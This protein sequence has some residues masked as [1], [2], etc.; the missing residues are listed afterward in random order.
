M[1]QQDK[2]D[3][4]VTINNG[5]ALRSIQQLEGASRRLRRE[6]RKATTEA[7]RKKLASDLKRVNTELRTLRAETRP[8]TNGLGKLTSSFN[9][10]AGVAAG[11]V[12]FQ[13]ITETFNNLIQRGAKL[14]DALS[15][16]QK[17]TGLT[18]QEVR[19]LDKDLRGIDTRS[20]R[21]ELLALAKEGGRLGITGVA[22]LRRFVEEADKINVALGEDLGDDAVLQIGKIADAFDTSMT[23]IAS[24][25]NT[26]GQNTKAQE[27]YLVDFVARMQGT[28]R[29]ANLSA[30]EIIGFGAT[31]DSLG[32]KVEMSGT[33]LN[34]FF[35]DF[36]KNTQDYAEAAGFAD[37]ELQKIIGEEGTNAGFLA[38]I[39]RLR[40]AN[41]ESDKFLQKLEDLGINGARGAQVFLA[42]SENLK[43]VHDNQ[44]MANDA[45]NEGTSI[46]E[47]F[48]TRNNNFAA[49]VNRV[50]K[51]L[52]SAFMNSA[53]ME[54]VQGI[55][56][57]LSDYLRVPLSEKLEK[58][59][60]QLN[61]L[62]GRITEL[63]TDN[64]T[65]RDLLQQLNAEYPDFLKNIDTETASND[66]LL[67]RLKQ[68]NEQMVNRLIIQRKQEEV[69]DQ[70]EKIASAKI[71]QMETEA[72]IRTRLQEIANEYN[73]ELDQ[74]A[75]LTEKYN[76]V[77]KHLSDGFNSYGMLVDK[78]K[79]RNH[80][81]YELQIELRG[82]TSAYNRAV[83]EGNDLIS[84]REML[85]KQLGLQLEKSID[86]E[87]DDG[88]DDDD[89]DVTGVSK[90]ELERKKQLYQQWLKELQTLQLQSI[91]DVE[92]QKIAKSKA[93]YDEERARIEQEV[94]DEDLKHELLAQLYR[95]F[96]SEKDEIHAIATEERLKAEAKKV[97]DANSSE[98]FTLQ[99]KYD[100]A[101]DGS[102]EQLQAL[103]NLLYKQM[104]LELES[105]ELTKEQK[106]L[107]QQDYSNRMDAIWDDYR[108]RQKEKDLEQLEWSEMTFGQRMEMINSYISTYG[109]MMLDMMNMVFD[110]ANQNLEAEHENFIATQEAEKE[111]LDQQLQDKVINKATYDQ[112]MLKMEEERERKERALK[113][114][115]FA[116]DKAARATQAI[117]NVA[118]GVTSAL[119]VPPPA[120]YIL[121]ALTAAMGAA[122]VAVITSQPNP[123]Y[124]GGYTDITDTEGNRHHA[125]NIGSFAD[126]GYYSTASYGVVGE[127]GTE[128]VVPNHVLNN[129][130]Y[131]DS[132]AHI[133]RAIYR[134]DLTTP[135]ADGG[136][137]KTKVTS[138]GK[139]SDSVMQPPNK[140]GKEVS[141]Q[142]LTM[143]LAAL[144]G[145][146]TKLNNAL[147]ANG[148]FFKGIWEWDAF[149]EGVYQ[150]EE[151]EGRHYFD[152]DTRG[153]VFNARDP[154]EKV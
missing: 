149:T 150:Q 137:T 9:K 56:G 110:F 93:A 41:P 101:E 86:G 5:E 147:D 49:D 60:V 109:N 138:T 53:I 87:G 122:E 30:S 64:E 26:L 13:V 20:S 125:M 36:V 70:N 144:T 153:L 71:K 90:E 73:I 117:I 24:S 83:E 123:Y 58:E 35:I 92:Q 46:L 112:K 141:N 32:L 44:R 65:R 146:M 145:Q 102:M 8:A 16:V 1:S 59:N 115:Q 104:T 34:N 103:E 47:E 31:L 88:S 27:G 154:G 114:K 128:L 139:D 148:G 54:G 134:K 77:Q 85:M 81:L 51:A 95:N 130:D 15:D 67:K 142:Q 72:R 62:V 6:W 124:K 133:E 105:A 143:A 29:T 96:Q 23:K 132:I 116:N 19:Q 135:F 151:V 57:T 12:G 99:L 33:A 94:E 98:L 38:F 111:L 55:F 140:S 84:E 50:Q 3:V 40:E 75:S 69:E 14:S 25:I 108:E 61:V 28:G 52:R 18:D 7:D 82:A 136:Y 113:R 37:G 126:G 68:V 48:N 131:R 121:A 91:T 76:Q 79:Q 78:N 66:Q 43:D 152:A 4:V 10:L 107:I 17:T 129:P 106:L 97:A 80:E 22:N 2:R 11:F 39:E 100:V 63:N 42:I 21:K 74:T 119:G 118:L 120:G 127:R 45:F 89:N